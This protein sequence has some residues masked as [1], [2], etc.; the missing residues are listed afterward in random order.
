VER[1]NWTIRLTDR[2]SER[3]IPWLRILDHRPLGGRDIELVP[4]LGA[5]K[6]TR[7]LRRTRS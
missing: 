6:R 3:R 5:S 2:R 7:V 4:A 1:P